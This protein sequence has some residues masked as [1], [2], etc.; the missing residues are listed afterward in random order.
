MGIKFCGFTISDCFV[1]ILFSLNFN[2]S[3]NSASEITDSLIFDY[4]CQPNLKYKYGTP[5]ILMKPQY[6]KIQLMTISNIKVYF[7]Y[8]K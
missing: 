2:F 1:G 6:A 8:N 3:Y 5:Q 4:V 7:S